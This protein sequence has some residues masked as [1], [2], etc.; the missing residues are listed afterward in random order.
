MILF[1]LF[2]ILDTALLK[3]H[4]D[5]LGLAYYPCFKDEEKLNGDWT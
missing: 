3:L 2:W 4:N 1:C 5:N